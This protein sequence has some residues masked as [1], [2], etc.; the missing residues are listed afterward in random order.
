LNVK[1]VALVFNLQILCTNFVQA[2]A[3][4]CSVCN[5]AAKG[6]AQR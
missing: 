1:L 6:K 2:W 4:A 3:E 5:K